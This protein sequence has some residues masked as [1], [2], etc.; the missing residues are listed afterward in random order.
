M[1]WMSECVSNKWRA[2]I[3]VDV[4]VDVDVECLTTG[5]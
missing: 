4:D 5:S 1:G 3:N 2:P